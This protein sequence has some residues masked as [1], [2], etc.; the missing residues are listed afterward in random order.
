MESNTE[1]NLVQAGGSDEDSSVLSLSVTTPTVDY[2]DNAEWILDTRAT[3]HVCPNRA[4]FSS[5]KKL[6]DVT[7]SWVMIIRVI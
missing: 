1:A 4:W 6:V 5:F 2:S 7:R 3:Y